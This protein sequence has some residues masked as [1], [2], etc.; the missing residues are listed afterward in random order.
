MST[1]D[2]P[3]IILGTARLGNGASLRAAPF[4]FRDRRVDAYQGL[5]K[6]FGT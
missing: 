5:T 6:R 3:G 2:A 4:F 1:D